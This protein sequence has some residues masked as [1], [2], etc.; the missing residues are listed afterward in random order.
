MET[1][2]KLSTN[3]TRSL[4]ALTVAVVLVVGAS[5]GVA[6]AYFTTYARALGSRPVTLGDTTTIEEE[7]DEYGKH[8]TIFNDT[9]SAQPVYVRVAAFIGKEGE[10]NISLGQGWMQSGEYKGKTEGGYGYFYYMQPL[11]PGERTSVLDIS[12][13]LP[14][15]LK[16]EDDPNVIVVHESTP[17]L[18]SGNYSAESGYGTPIASNGPD[19]VGW[20]LKADQVTNKTPDDTEGGN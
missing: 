8:I 20:N 3:T 7:V 4:I 16:V 5:I 18:Y 11:K 17:V 9:D 1:N 12:I 6:W 13:K 2:K 10:L 19:Y 14:E 15:K